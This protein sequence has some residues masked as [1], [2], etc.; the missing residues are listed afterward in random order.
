MCRS[1]ATISPNLAAAW[2]LN[3]AWTARYRNLP[4]ILKRLPA[5]SNYTKR[6]FLVNRVALIDRLIK[7]A[8]AEAEIRAREL[9][10]DA[11]KKK[12]EEAA[13][14]SKSETGGEDEAGTKMEVEADGVSFGCSIL[15]QLP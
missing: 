9:K 2:K 3:Q 4:A 15:W 12:K 10:E 5:D 13:E 11:E 1:N 14:K 7:K 8:G 6:R